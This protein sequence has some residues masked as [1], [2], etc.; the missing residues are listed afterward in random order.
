MES[1]ASR[2][3]TVII[4][5]ERLPVRARLT[6]RWRRLPAGERR[7]LTAQLAAALVFAS[8]AWA[9]E[10]YDTAVIVVAMTGS[11]IAVSLGAEALESDHRL[12]RKLNA[13]TRRT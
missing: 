12:T 13:P 10:A 6:R 11:G 8:I 9:V 3:R 1:A 5:E 4:L 2:A 7:T